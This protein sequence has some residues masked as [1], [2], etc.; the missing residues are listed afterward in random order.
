MDERIRN[1]VDTLKISKE[2]SLHSISPARGKMQQSPQIDIKHLEE[3]LS[4]RLS[5]SIEQL[6][7]IIKDYARKYR[8]LNERTGDIESKLFGQPRDEKKKIKT[9]GKENNGINTSSANIANSSV[10]KRNSIAKSQD[11]DH[12]PPVQDKNLKKAKTDRPQVILKKSASKDFKQHSFLSNPYTNTTQEV[13]ASQNYGS[14]NR[15]S[16]EEKLLLQGLKNTQGAHTESPRGLNRNGR[17]QS[18]KSLNESN[19]NAT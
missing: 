8:K 6:A 10:L 12:S 13:N 2:T 4:K 16:F 1:E 19:Q 5:E 17:E 3:K 7:E 15:N 9:K 18:M 11:R 14:I